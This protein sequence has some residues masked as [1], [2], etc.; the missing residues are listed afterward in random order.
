LHDFPEGFAMAN[1]YMASPELGILVALAIAIHNLP[2]EF[3]MAVPVVPLRT[4][5]LLY[6][7]A[8]LSALAEPA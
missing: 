4:K 6:G 3:A 5:K 1:S 7:A 8:A 2:E